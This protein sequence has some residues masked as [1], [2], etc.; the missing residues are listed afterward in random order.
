MPI[1]IDPDTIKAA[2]VPPSEEVTS[3]LWEYLVVSL[4][5]MIILVGFYIL[6]IGPMY[7][8]WVGAKQVDGSYYIAAIYE[9][10][11][12]L[13]GVFPDLGEWLNWYVRFWIF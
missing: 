3:G 13:A 11:W 8:S 5:Q 9:P 6:S 4:E 7:W 2:P 1:E 10:L 12:F